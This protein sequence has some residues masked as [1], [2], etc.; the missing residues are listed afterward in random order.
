MALEEA[1]PAAVNAP[2]QWLFRPGL[3]AGLPLPIAVTIKLS[4]NLR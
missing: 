4:F 3:M 1:P 2:R